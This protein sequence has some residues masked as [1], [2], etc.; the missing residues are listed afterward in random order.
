MKG[1]NSTFYNEL[2]NL[3]E[4]EYSSVREYVVICLL[5]FMLEFGNRTFF[6]PFLEQGN[7]TGWQVSSFFHAVCV[8][9]TVI[10]VGVLALTPILA[11]LCI[12]LWRL[13]LKN[14]RILNKINEQRGKIT[15][16]QKERDKEGVS[17][18]MDELLLTLLG[19]VFIFVVMWFAVIPMMILQLYRGVFKLARRY[20]CLKKELKSLLKEQE[21][22]FEKS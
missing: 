9:W 12:I 7:L 10:A 8:L 22:A 18:K 6:L 2:L 11:I 19:L 21:T 14:A 5:S 3:F 20:G 17:V 15:P 1:K 13:L 16:Q 4:K